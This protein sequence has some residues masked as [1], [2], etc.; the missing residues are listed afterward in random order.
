VGPQATWEYRRAIAVRYRQAD[1]RAKGQILDECCEVTGYHRKSA[2]RMLRVPLERARPRR[3]RGRT[4]VSSARTLEGLVAIWRAAGYPW[5]V[6]L[7]ALLPPW[8]GWARRRFALPATVEAAWAR[9]SP[10]QMDRRLQPHKRQLATRLYGRTKPGTL[11]KQHIPIQTERW[12]VT[13]P[14]FPEIELVSPAGDCADGAFLH[15]LNVTDIHTPWVET[16]AG[17]G[18][19]QAR[20]QQALAAMRAALPFRLRGIE[21]DNGSDFINHHLYRD[22][23]AEDIQFTRGACFR[24]CGCRPSSS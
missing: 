10:R 11:L 4:A 5:S 18:K 7:K 13:T 19:G 2:I 16:R 23:Q 8:L 12:S 6:R 3:G 17:M 24:I 20:V 22:C 15:S 9:I 14:G 21:S 1:R